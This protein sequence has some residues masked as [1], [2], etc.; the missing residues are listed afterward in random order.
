M[1]RAGWVRL[2]S[3]KAGAGWFDRSTSA[4]ELFD[5]DAVTACHTATAQRAKTRTATTNHL[6][7]RIRLLGDVG[8]GSATGS[9]EGELGVDAEFTVFF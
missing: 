9:V 4:R 2:D 3:A 6:R 7:R 1:V 8:A 5:V